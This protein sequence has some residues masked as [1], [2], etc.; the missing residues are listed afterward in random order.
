MDFT[1]S[2]PFLELEL[3]DANFCLKKLAFA[4]LIDCVL[5][6][7]FLE[8]LHIA[9]TIRCQRSPPQDVFVLVEG[10]QV[11]SEPRAISVISSTFFE[12]DMLI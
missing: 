12:R 4:F 7:F 6:P 10:S 9:G 3:Q 11:W 5:V 2:Q 1:V 8:K